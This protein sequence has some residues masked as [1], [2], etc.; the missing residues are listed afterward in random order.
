MNEHTPSSNDRLFV[1]VAA[2]LIGGAVVLLLSISMAIKPWPR[3]LSATT[4]PNLLAKLPDDALELLLPP[5]RS[6]FHDDN[7]ERA[8][9]HNR[10]QMEAYGRRVS[11]HEAA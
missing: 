8:E 6:A 1:L 5:S 9:R 11:R 10:Y 7:M 4:G 3:S 2:G